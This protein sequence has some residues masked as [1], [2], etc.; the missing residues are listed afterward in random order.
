MVCLEVTRLER[1]L[2]ALKGSKA[3]LRS[4]LE[5]AHREVQHRTTELQT[6]KTQAAED[7]A[8]LEALEAS[9][10]VGE[11]QSAGLKEISSQL[12]KSGE[13]LARLV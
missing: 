3:L 6:V 2:S 8:A 5:A 11:L 10:E 1:E 7:R 9:K 13:S 12:L 4:A